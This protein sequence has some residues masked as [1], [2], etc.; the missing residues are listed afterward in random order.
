ML[1]MAVFKRISDLIGDCNRL[2][3]TDINNSVTVDTG[4]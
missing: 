2:F 3:E 1:S 4:Y